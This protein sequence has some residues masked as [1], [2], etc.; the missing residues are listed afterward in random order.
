MEFQSDWEGKASI[1]AR[2]QKTKKV[3]EVTSDDRSTKE[4]HGRDSRR[5]GKGRGKITEAKGKTLKEV[6]VGHSLE[7]RGELLNS[8][9]RKRK[10]RKTA[11]AIKR[12][13]DV[14]KRSM[15]RMRGGRK[16][17]EVV[18]THVIAIL[19][20]ANLTQITLSVLGKRCLF[21]GRMREMEKY[22]K[23]GSEHASVKT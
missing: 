15:D 2:R 3:F 7:G 18:S 11:Q 9:R 17:R 21:F 10:Y 16:K 20:T 6:L 1:E 13:I 19:T 5:I 12:K 23:T 14:E 4:H 8:P 22:W